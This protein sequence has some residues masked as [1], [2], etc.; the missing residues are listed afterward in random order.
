MMGFKTNRHSR[1]SGNPVENLIYPI[2]IDLKT[3]YPKIP[4]GIRYM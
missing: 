1:T 3:V 2:D 4:Y